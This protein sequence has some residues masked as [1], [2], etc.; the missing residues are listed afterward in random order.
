MSVQKDCL[1]NFSCSQNWLVDQETPEETWSARNRRK[2]WDKWDQNVVPLRWREDKREKSM[3][4][5]FKRTLIITTTKCKI[6][7]HWKSGTMPGHCKYC[8]GL[9]RDLKM[10]LQEYMLYPGRPSFLREGFCSMDASQGPV[11]G[12]WSETR[13]VM[14]ELLLMGLD[15]K[16]S[17]T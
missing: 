13:Q 1:N 17:S 14:S 7:E 9:R 12:R 4:I 10:K 2:D 3:K 5:K 15:H 16:E 11:S 8:G 6:S